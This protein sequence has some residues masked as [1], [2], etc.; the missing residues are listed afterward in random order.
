[1]FKNNLQIV[2]NGQKIE[3]SDRMRYFCMG[4][5]LVID[6]IKRIGDEIQKL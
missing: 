1:M 6:I 4:N 3:V 5:A 2:E